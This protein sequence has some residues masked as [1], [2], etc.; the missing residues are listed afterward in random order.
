M[1]EA[2]VNPL[3]FFPNRRRELQLTDVYPKLNSESEKRLLLEF[4]MPLTTDNLMGAPR[5]VQAAFEAIAKLDNGIPQAPIETE[6]E[7]VGGE[8][9]GVPDQR[10]P[11]SLVV[12]A[13]FRKLEVKREESGDVVLTFNTTVPWA[14]KLWSWAGENLGA[15][16]FAEFHVTQP[17]LPMKQE[18][19]DGIPDLPVEQKAAVEEIEPDKKPEAASERKGR[20]KKVQEEEAVAVQ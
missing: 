3:E 17:M 7:G 15:T 5:Q 9:F 8:F 16:M 10:E 14:T 18:S 1:N 6:F 13:T 4:K 19:S 11:A 20:R 12:A 2:I